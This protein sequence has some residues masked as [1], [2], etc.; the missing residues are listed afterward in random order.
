MQNRPEWEPDW[1]LESLLNNHI[2]EMVDR[3]SCLRAIRVDLFYQHHTTK[4][5]LQNHRQLERDLRVLMAGMMQVEVVVGFFW[6][7]EWTEDHHYHAHVAFWLDGKYTQKPY[8]WAEKARELWMSITEGDGWFHRCEFKPHYSANINIPVRYD[9][10]DSIANIRQVLV[11]MT[12]IEQKQG[13]PLFGCNEVP[14]RPLSGRPRK[15]A[16]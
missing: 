8:L 7:I 3:Y 1:Y 14:E 15:T 16:F 12:K 2:T 6:V 10:P 4:Y 5:H 13:M 9:D 11:Y